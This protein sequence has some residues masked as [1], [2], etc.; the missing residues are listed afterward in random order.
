MDLVSITGKNKTM[1]Q[2][3]K[4]S[5]NHLESDVNRSV[6]ETMDYVKTNTETNLVE[7]IRRENLEISTSDI[8][9]LTHIVKASIDQAFSRG[10]MQVEKTFS[11]YK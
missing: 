3:I 5:I 7:T 1:A 9:N 4:K 10:Y 6:A 11:S 8:R 2:N